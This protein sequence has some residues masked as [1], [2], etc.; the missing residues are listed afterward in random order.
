MIA[1]AATATGEISGAPISVRQF[2]MASPYP[3]TDESSKSYR[4]RQNI[5]PT[6]IKGIKLRK[7]VSLNAVGHRNSASDLRR[8]KERII[9]WQINP[10]HRN[11]TASKGRRSRKIA[12]MTVPMTAMKNAGRIAG[13]K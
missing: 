7:M 1:M 11:Q 8:R 5:G 10:L 6:E 2:L 13:S 3:P 9:Q 12:G 4:P